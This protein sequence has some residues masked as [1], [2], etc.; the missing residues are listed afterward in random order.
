[1][2]KT[3]TPTITVI[4]DDPTDIDVVGNTDTRSLADVLEI[5]ALHVAEMYVTLAGKTFKAGLCY[6]DE[7]AIVEVEVKA[8]RGNFADVHDLHK[9][10]GTI[11]IWDQCTVNGVRAGNRCGARNE[12]MKVYAPI[13]ALAAANNS[14][15]GSPCTP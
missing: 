8:A 2:K 14:P 6:G 12:M 4:N 9:I 13:V 11:N 5:L 15:K 3:N 7:V 1:M 10:G